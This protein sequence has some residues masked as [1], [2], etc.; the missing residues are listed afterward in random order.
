VIVYRF[1][2]SLAQLNVLKLTF[3][4]NGLVGNFNPGRGA[5]G[6]I[7]ATPPAPL[8]ATSLIAW[9]KTKADGGQHQQDIASVT[10]SNF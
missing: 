7:E 5:A 3:L 2:A 4:A 9:I 1:E 10:Y 6:R 8:M